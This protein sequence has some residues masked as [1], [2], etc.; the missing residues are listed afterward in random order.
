VVEAQLAQGVA[1]DIILREAEEW[2][3]RAG[4]TAGSL[5][6]MARFVLRS[7]LTEGLPQAEA[8]AREGV[9]SG[10]PGRVMETLPLVL[11]AQNKWK[12]AVQAS[13]P[14]MDAAADYK[15]PQKSIT[16]FLVQAAANGYA[17]EGLELLENSKG[18]AALEPLLV[19]LRIY[20]GEAPQVA[21]EIL[22]I[23]KDVAERI[24][25]VSLSNKPV[26]RP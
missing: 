7:N 9:S 13:R 1:N 14:L 12:E 18:A 26:V 24:R 6:S 22:E 23:G 15:E 17:R 4:R 20:L 19:G 3:E 8:W 16:E 11:A 25:H 2:I 5:D 10:R 21:K